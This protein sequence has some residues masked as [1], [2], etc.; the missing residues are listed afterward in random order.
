[1]LQ[2]PQ[3]NMFSVQFPHSLGLRC[4]VY[5][6]F[7][8]A[9]NS[10]KFFTLFVECS[11]GKK[12]RRK[13]SPKTDFCKK[14]SMNKTEILLLFFFCSTTHITHNAKEGETESC[15]LFVKEFKS[16]MHM[17]RGDRRASENSRHTLLH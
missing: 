11:G 6:S 17:S 4:C 7:S 3:Q 1:M 14:R 15:L 2:I 10:I 5:S 16:F 8:L 13:G 9:L 12:Q